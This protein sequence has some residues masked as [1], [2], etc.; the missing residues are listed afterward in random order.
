MRLVALA[1]LCM[2]VF[3]ACS[4]QKATVLTLN[5]ANGFGPEYRTTEARTKQAAFIA[6]QQPDVVALQEV[7]FGVARSGG[8]DT[9]A[10]ALGD[11]AKHGTLIYGRESYVDAQ[12]RP[13]YDTDVGQG[14]V[15]N[16]LWIS[17][18]FKVLEWW[19]VPLDFTGIWP[20]TA[21][22]ARVT[23]GSREV[24]VATTHLSEGPDNGA[25][26]RQLSEILSYPP[27][28]FLGDMN[29]LTS[30]MP[31]MG[32]LKPVLQAGASPGCIDQVWA[33]VPATGSLVP[34]MGVSDHPYAA[35]ADIDL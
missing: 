5:I 33:R 6:S 26:N 2:L 32:D 3:V 4:G 10:Q 1:I 13:T 8:G 17:E 15:G 14:S 30:D 29:M 12:G 19:I 35:R 34:T 9:G 21:I 28:L 24:I 23:D 27:D 11:L 20:R 16:S 18:R 31:V 25:R 22:F 7:D